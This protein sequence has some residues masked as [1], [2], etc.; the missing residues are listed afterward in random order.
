MTEMAEITSI[1]D[2]IVKEAERGMEPSGARPMAAAFKATTVPGT[3]HDFFCAH[4]EDIKK[5]IEFLGGLGGAWGKLVASVLIRI[6]DSYQKKHC[7]S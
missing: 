7:L 3:G 6:G 5:A 1:V 2:Q 4:W